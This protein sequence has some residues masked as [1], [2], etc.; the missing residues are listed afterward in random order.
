[1]GNY[2]PGEFIHDGATQIFLITTL[3]SR[4]SLDVFAGAEYSE[5]TDFPNAQVESTVSLSVSNSSKF[6]ISDPFARRGSSDNSML[7]VDY[8]N[9]LYDG[10]Y[11]ADVNRVI[12]IN[13]FPFV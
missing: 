9:E 8:V 2:W 12:R 6:S 13:M 11:A 7:C 5:P 1:V 10:F 3:E 4:S